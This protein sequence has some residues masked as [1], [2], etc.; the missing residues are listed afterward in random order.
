V[1]SLPRKQAVTARVI[2]D[3]ADLERLEQ[4]ARERGV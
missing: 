3:L 1:P 2:R 4:I